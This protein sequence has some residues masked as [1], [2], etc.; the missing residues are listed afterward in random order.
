VAR[1]RADQM[2]EAARAARGAPGLRHAWSVFIGQPLSLSVPPDAAAEALRAARAGDMT[3]AMR[4]VAKPVRRSLEAAARA[5]DE[6]S[7]DVYNAGAALSEEAL[8]AW[9]EAV[10]P[11]RTVRRVELDPGE[12]PAEIAASWWFGGAPESLVVTF[13]PDGRPAEMFRHVGRAWFKGLGEVPI[14]EIAAETGGPAEIFRA[15]RT[16]WLGSAPVR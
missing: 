9:L 8:A 11:K 15:L 5:E 4:A 14:W 7:G 2:L 13:L 1:A 6:G 10:G 3:S 16:A 12:I